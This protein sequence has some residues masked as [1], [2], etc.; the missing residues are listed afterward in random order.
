MGHVT[1][2]TPLYGVIFYLFGKT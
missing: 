2:T 1:I